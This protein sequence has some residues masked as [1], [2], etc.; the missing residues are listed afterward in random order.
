MN[1]K[2]VRLEKSVGIINL[3]L[4]IFE[5]IGG[6]LFLVL[7]GTIAEMFNGTFGNAGTGAATA[8]NVMT[9]VV[10][11]AGVLMMI[12]GIIMIVLA[13]RL[14]RTPSVSDNGVIADRKGIVI[15]FL[16]INIIAFLG[17]I[18]NFFGGAAMAV[19]S[20]VVMLAYLASAILAGLSLRERHD[21]SYARRINNYNG[22]Y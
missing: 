12:L 14:I 2:K 11:V 13:S 20:I 16:V 21:G 10:I 8:G 5:T 9:A 17:S 7:S 4:G 19:S 15:F 3:I 22:S 1:E 6:F 18:M